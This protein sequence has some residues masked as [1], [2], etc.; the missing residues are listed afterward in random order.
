MIVVRTRKRV[1]RAR[2][3]SRGE[4]RRMVLGYMGMIL[5]LEKGIL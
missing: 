5:E 1:R 4:L 2:G 3:L